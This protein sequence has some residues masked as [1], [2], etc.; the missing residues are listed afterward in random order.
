MTDPKPRTEDGAQ[1]LVESFWREYVAGYPWSTAEGV[2]RAKAALVS[3]I[4]AALTTTR[5]ELEQARELA[6]QDLCDMQTAKDQVESALDKAVAALAESQRRAQ[7]LAEDYNV[8]IHDV[9][10]QQRR[11]QEAEADADSWLRK[12]LTARAEAQAL[13]E[14]LLR[15]E[16]HYGS[17]RVL[18]QRTRERL[19]E[20]RGLLVMAADWISSVNDIV[21]ERIVL[22]RILAFLAHPVAVE[23]MHICD[24][25]RLLRPC[26][27]AI[28][29]SEPEPPA[30]VRGGTHGFVV[31]GTGNWCFQ[32]LVP[33]AESWLK[34]HMDE[35]Y[36]GKPAS[37]PVHAVPEPEPTYACARCGTLRTK[38]EGGTTFTVCDECWTEEHPAVVGKPEPE[39]PKGA[40]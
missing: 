13:R 6:H 29:P 19:E 27:H 3:A 36:C 16:N 34:S 39:P 24:E 23:R 20:A 30:E 11:A 10:L 38:A 17:E 9:A 21:P 40:A 1:A 8:A 37:D 32:R 15:A 4:E 25:L 18:H 2:Q 5:Q 7:E 31:G 28:A 14:Q 35:P 12:C 26:P 33:G 22:D